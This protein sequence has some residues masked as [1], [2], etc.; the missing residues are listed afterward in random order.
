VSHP[1]PPIGTIGWLD[2]TVPDA[3]RLRDFYAAVCG[4]THEGLSMGDY[5]DYVMKAPDGTPVGGVC[6]ARGPNAGVPPHW[7]SY[8]V[9]ADLS[10]A[11]A[12]ATK[13]GGT[14]IDGPRSAGSGRM[15][16]IRDPAGAT[17][18]LYQS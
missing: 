3:P 10:A 9:I 6:H 7:I 2:L 12:N 14:V 16:I 1:A 4:W 15:A 17:F 13:L 5:E 8:A 11:I 18:G